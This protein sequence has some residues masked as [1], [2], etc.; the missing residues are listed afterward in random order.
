LPHACEV[1]RQTYK[2]FFRDAMS[3][4]ILD[5]ESDGKSSR[6]IEV[7]EAT[8][9]SQKYRVYAPRVG[10]SGQSLGSAFNATGRGPRTRFGRCHVDPFDM[11]ALI[12]RIRRALADPLNRDDVIDPM[13]ELGALLS[14]VGLDRASG[15]GAVSFAGRD[16]IVASPLPFATMAA[17]ALMAKSISVAALWR[18]R[19]GAGQDMSVDLGEALH[20]LCPFYDRKWE[21][22]NG[23]AP[24]NP[25]DPS[26]P[27][28]PT[29]M[30]R[31]RDGR[32]AL[33]MNI[34]PRIRSAA[35]A[36]LGCNDDPRAIGAVIRKWDAFEFEEQANR[37]GLQATIVR[38]PEEFLQSEQCHCLASLPLVHIEKIADGDPQPFAASPVRPLDGVRALGFSHVI[39]G[40]GMG[41]AFAYHGADVLN[42][43]QPTSFEIDFNYYTANVGMRSATL[44]LSHPEGMGR[45]RRLVS[46][47][48]VFFANRRPGQI[49]KLGLSTAEL[50]SLRPGIVHVDIS[51]YGREGPWAD[52]IGFD[53][54]AG[55]VTGILALEGSVEIVDHESSA[56]LLG[57]ADKISPGSWHPQ[58]K[59]LINQG[60]DHE[61]ACRVDHRWLNRHRAHRRRRF[62]QEGRE[63]GCRRPA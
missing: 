38:S 33:F 10:C 21:L 49:D 39:A 59:M 16:P 58:L 29:N 35:L 27:F 13:Q 2:V 12:D 28:M 42:I 26:N 8:M 25:A 44:D 1:W 9:E 60:V 17:V 51:I 22:L 24:G 54:T 6:S 23:Y 55:G 47:A 57:E 50:A 48:D 4:Q 36:F 62:R 15:G 11:S 37:A 18:F 56:N 5:R 3:A 46:Q 30:Y 45:L 19:G 41:R 7:A 43:W 61:Y 20:R 14:E 34:Y 31:T 53:H 63:G 32:R 52:R 40:P